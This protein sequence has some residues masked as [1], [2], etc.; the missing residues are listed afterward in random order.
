MESL[1]EIIRFLQSIA[2]V[3]DLIYQTVM[4][5][6]ER[7]KSKTIDIMAL[8]YDGRVKIRL[9]DD[10]KAP[11]TIKNEQD[12]RIKRLS[13]MGYNNTYIEVLV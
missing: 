10:S 9:R 5:I 13:V 2:E 1:W 4:E 12:D 3:K 6:V 8:V 7:R 11:E